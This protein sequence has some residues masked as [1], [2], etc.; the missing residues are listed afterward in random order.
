MERQ[1][2]MYPLA[3]EKWYRKTG[4][5]V[6]SRVGVRIFHNEAKSV[7][8]LHSLPLYGVDQ[9]RHALVLSISGHD[10]AYRLGSLPRP[11]QQGQ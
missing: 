9:G 7:A 2:R 8:P 4:S 3:P 1:V 5:Y 10:T 11:Q 6:A